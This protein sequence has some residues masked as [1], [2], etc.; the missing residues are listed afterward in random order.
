MEKILNKS[1][2]RGVMIYL[3]RWKRFI[4]ENDTWGKE[5]DL[6]NTKE[7]IAE[8]ERRISVEVGR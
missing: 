7:I 4:V 1:E 8:F 5:E 2:L 3:I 6:E